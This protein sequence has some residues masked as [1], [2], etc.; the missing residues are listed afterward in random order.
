MR[1]RLRRPVVRGAYQAD[2]GKKENCTQGKVD[3]YL[4]DIFRTG[5]AIH[6]VNRAK[7]EAG[8]PENSENN[9]YYP[10]FHN[11]LL[12]CSCKLYAS[13][14]TIQSA[15]SD[16]AYSLTGIAMR[17][18]S[19]LTAIPVGH[20]TSIS[21]SHRVVNRLDLNSCRIFQFFAMPDEANFS[22]SSRIAKLILSTVLMSRR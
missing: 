1:N 19:I 8:N 15:A 6:K 17:L 22:V 2:A 12:S 5:A 21:S 9:T 11:S 7:D 20:L 16:E 10:F 14:N 3:Q 18:F 13:Q 4:F